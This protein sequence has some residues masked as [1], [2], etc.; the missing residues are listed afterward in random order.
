MHRVAPACLLLC[1]STIIQA[2]NQIPGT[3]SHA[4][5]VVDKLPWQFTLKTKKL[6]KKQSGLTGSTQSQRVS[7]RSRKPIKKTN[8]GGIYLR[9]TLTSHRF[10]NADAARDHFQK[11]VTSAHPDMGLSYAWDYLVLTRNH[12]HHLYG[13]CTISDSHFQQMIKNLDRILT[14]S[15]QMKNRTLLCRCGSG[16]REPTSNK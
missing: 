8:S 3:S 16:C 11:Q 9:G 2:G 10:N 12:I 7:F 4:K 13:E 6:A 14:S 5:G 15:G 1:F